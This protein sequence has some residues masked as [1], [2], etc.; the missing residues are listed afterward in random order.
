MRIY[1]ELASWYHLLTAPEEYVEEAGLYLDVIRRNVRRPLATLLELGSGGGNNAFHYKRHVSPTLTDLSPQMLELSRAINP[2]LEH[3]QGDM[4]TLRLG[5]SF[6]AVFCH[7][8]VVYMTTPEDLA[9]VMTT[10]FEHL[11]PGGV[12]LFTPDYTRDSFHPGT[13]TGG[14][15]R[16][17]RSLRYLEW[18]HDLDPSDSRYEVDYALI[19]R[20]AD[21]STRVEH[22]HHSEAV[23][24][25]AQ[26]LALLRAAGFDASLEAREFEVDGE[27]YDLR[28]FVGVR[29][30]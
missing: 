8:A 28:L 22:D 12:A 30:A 29:T 5:R 25:Q 27:C 11:A 6:D 2:E 18:V 24:E 10:A 26:W 19:L 4:R 20:D 15:D 7:D 13:S 16:D 14:N 23:F 21:G 1:G 17:G 9:A 3:I